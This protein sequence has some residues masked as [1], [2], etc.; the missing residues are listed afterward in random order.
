MLHRPR[1]SN[2]TV[3]I[4][5]K[6]RGGQIGDVPLVFDGEKTMYRDGSSGTE[7]A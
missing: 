7:F 4:V 6:N 5:E 1:D 3:L 2:D